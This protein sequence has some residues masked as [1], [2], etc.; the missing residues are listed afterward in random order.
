MINFILHRSIITGEVLCVFLSE[1][2]LFPFQLIS[3]VFFLLLKFK[4]NSY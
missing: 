2:K 1:M 3:S 4:L